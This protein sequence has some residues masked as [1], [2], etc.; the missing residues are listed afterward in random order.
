MTQRHRW[1]AGRGAF[2]VFVFLPLFLVVF[3]WS[4]VG[5]PVPPA[6]RPPETV[7]GP[8]ADLDRLIWD[9]KMKEALPL[10]ER[11]LAEA[12]AAGDQPA[13]TRALART[14]QIR[15]ARG[16]LEEGLAS[17]DREP[18]PADPVD[19]AVLHLFR[20]QALSQYFSSYTQEILA[21]EKIESR[22]AVGID[23]WTREQLGADILT[24]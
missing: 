9:Q 13:W 7:Q 15:R 12:R 5:Q 19:R 18:W 4:S 24:E 16:S 6:G 3:A 21:R 22:E 11:L 20:A 14:V 8:W 2:L 1:S 23:H 17:L 10:A